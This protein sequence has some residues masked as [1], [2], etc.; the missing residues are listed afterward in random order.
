[1]ERQRIDFWRGKWKSGW[2]ATPVLG[3][4]KKQKP[5]LTFMVKMEFKAVTSSCQ[6]RDSLENKH[7]YHWQNGG[8]R[9]I[10][11]IRID[12]YTLLSHFS[13]VWLVAISFSNAW[14]WKVKGKS[15]SRVWPSA[16]PWT[17]A[18]Q[19][20]PSMGFSRQEYWSGMPLPSPYI[21]TTIYKIGN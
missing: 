7:G 3:L 14:K 16:T 19:A 1:V 5:H 8:M 11:E 18:F 13:R 20:P 17:A 10:G 15:L 12:I 4:Q 9:W 2:S 21:Y 6:N